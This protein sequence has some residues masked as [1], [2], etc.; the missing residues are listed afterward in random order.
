SL[1]SREVIA[2]SI[3]TVGRGQSMDGMLV[4]GGC[5]KNMPGG[6]IALARL[7]VPSIY[8]YGGTIKP[9]RLN[10][11]DLTIVSVFEAVGAHAAGRIELETLRQVEAH[12]CPGPGSCG[13]MYTANT[14]SSAIEALGMALPY[15]STIA[16]EDDEAVA[17]AR[18]S[19]EAL[20]ELVRRNVTPRQIMTKQ[21]FENA[22]RVVMA[23]GGST[24]AV[25][26]LL[27]IAHSMG[28]DLTIDDFEELRR[29]TPVLCDLKPSGRYVATDL[30]AVGGIQL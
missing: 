7:D 21:A 18:A 1:V 15:S 14:M 29:T 8:V 26:H 23:V 27:A 25:L 19:G 4:V 2:D 24:N 13:G 16:S 11:E 3:E 6:M 9:G 5:D 22:V 17:H 12:A 28:V 10:G 30:H 20:V